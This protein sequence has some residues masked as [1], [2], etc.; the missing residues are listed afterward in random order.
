MGRYAFRALRSKI[1]T[2]ALQQELYHNQE[3][4]DVAI[5]VVGNDRPSPAHSPMSQTPNVILAHRVVLAAHSPQL[6]AI[7]AS[8]PASP[9][10]T[11][12]H[13]PI[14]RSRSVESASSP[15]QHTVRFRQ[16]PGLLKLGSG[17]SDGADSGHGPGVEDSTVMEDAVFLSRP[18]MSID[19]PDT[20]VS[21]VRAILDFAYTG[22]LSVN[23]DRIEE[24][25]KAAKALGF[26]EIEQLIRQYLSKQP[27]AVILRLLIA[28]H[29]KRMRNS[30]RSSAVYMEI[31]FSLCE[32]QFEVLVTCPE[33]LSMP[34]ELFHALLSSNRL[35]LQSEELVFNTV[36]QWT[37]HQKTN[38]PQGP[39]YLTSLISL[40]RL[41]FL[42][43]QFLTYRV[44]PLASIIQGSA[45]QDQYRR[46][47]VHHRLV[48]PDPTLQ[49]N[50]TMFS[51][52]SPRMFQPE[53]EACLIALTFGGS[54]P[55]DVP[56]I[57]YLNLA[58][59]GQPL[60][61][62]WRTIGR[63]TVS[64]H[65][66][67]VV[68]SGNVLYVIGGSSSNKSLDT[69]QST[70]VMHDNGKWTMQP[71]M[72][73]RRDSPAAAVFNRDI[74][75]IGG[76]TSGQTLDLVEKFSWRLKRWCLAAPMSTPRA[77]AGVATNDSLIFVAGG[78]VGNHALASVECYD[79]QENEWYPLPDMQVPR[80][81]PCV[82]FVNK[83][84]VVFGGHSLA[85]VHCSAE[86]YDASKR[87]WRTLA[88]MKAPRTCASCVVQNEK[89]LIGGGHD[90][91]HRL[92]SIDEYDLE[93]NEWR[94]SSL[95]SLTS[96]DSDS[97]IFLVP[98]NGAR[99]TIC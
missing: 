74:Y 38:H 4:C 17:T 14:T 98:F 91:F 34:F 99:E 69:F 97:A 22:S 80:I 79:V 88:N 54:A 68:M 30:S 95:P 23:I 6:R 64:Q 49:L 96:T 27:P 40:V 45:F 24:L 47:Q 50:C 39:D 81:S 72:L 55:S 11:P 12:L 51:Q 32:E 92:S 78:C 58:K 52:Y 28:A 73:A 76:C 67:A 16:H 66:P 86:Y 2:S 70:D 53:P 84:L 48:S 42:S 9:V 77:A 13:Y 20:A 41:P 18:I 35:V 62:R 21:A 10:T 63:R 43:P 1:S 61:L 29:L 65:H 36:L 75:A 82:V 8:S 15:S 83:R 85:H 71:T 37:Q 19:V 5:N 56:G 57:E 87:V 3:L 60:H 33:L 26:K 90:G 25:L 93:S 89:I 31:L 59:N 46:A 44:A 7:F 94:H